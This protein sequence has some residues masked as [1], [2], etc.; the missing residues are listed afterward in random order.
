M[1]ALEDEDIVERFL[2]G[3]LEPRVNGDFAVDPVGHG[4]GKEGEPV[5]DR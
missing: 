3:G 2:I 5:D 1:K 4:V